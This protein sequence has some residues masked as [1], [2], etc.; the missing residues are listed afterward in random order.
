[1]PTEPASTPSD[2]LIGNG[3]KSP[4]FEAFG[5]FLDQEV[6]DYEPSVSTSPIG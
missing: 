4:A 3:L 2:E 1:M 5:R 6:S